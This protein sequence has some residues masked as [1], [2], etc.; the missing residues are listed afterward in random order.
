[1]F[2]PVIHKDSQIVH[3]QTTKDCIEAWRSHGTLRRQ[4]KDIFDNVINSIELFLKNLDSPVSENK[5][6]SILHTTNIWM[7]QLK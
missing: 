7:A 3:Q 1:M 5:K 2:D 4:A 6:N